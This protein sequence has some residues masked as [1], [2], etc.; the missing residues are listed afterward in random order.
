MSR[1]PQTLAD[2]QNLLSILPDPSLT[3]QQQAMVR[4]AILTKPPGALGRLEEMAIW[5]ATWQGR[6][7]PRLERVLCVVFAGNHGVTA[8]GVSA[9]PA[10]V[11]RQMVANFQ[12]GGAAIN[13]LSTAFGAE[14]KILPLQLEQPTADFT[15]SA[16]MSEKEVLDALGMGWG[17]I[18]ED[19][20]LFIPGE[21][22]IG[23]TTA[24]AILAAALYGGS[25]IDW[26]GPGTGIDTVGLHRKAAV[27]DR[28]LAYHGSA[29]ADPLEALRRVGGRELA[30]MAG[31]ILAARFYRV[32]VLLDGFV[33]GASAA[34]WEKAH[35]GA[36][37]HTL[38][39]HVSA[40]PGHRRLLAC[41]NK[42][43]LLDL[44]MR[45]GEASGALTAL[46]LLRAA[47]VTHNGMATFAEAAVSGKID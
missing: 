31:A 40:E 32:P 33:C 25:G 5:L 10:E 2:W 12:A 23:N 35:P 30:G 22:G 3:S 4:N 38:A 21:M 1:K 43:P 8:Q 45:L 15:A 41:L 37:S 39:G 26:A 34:V 47:I 19:L 44:N 13:Q 9:F 42:A 14:L 29:L 7:P 27:I 20:D 46:G 36:L 16:A 6:H 28:A 24:A 18:K 17:C 11:T